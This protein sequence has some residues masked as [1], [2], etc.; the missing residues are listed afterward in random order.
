[1][2]SKGVRRE[3]KSYRLSNVGALP[4]RLLPLAGKR[5]TAEVAVLN[6]FGVALAADSAVTVD[7]WHQNK[8]ITKV[9]NSA[10]KVFTLSKFEPVGVLF[11]N[12]ATFG[13]IPW[14]TIVKVFRRQL[15]KTKLNTL[16]EYCTNF[17]G[18]LENNSLFTDA[19]VSDV[20]TSVFIRVFLDL[21]K[22]CKSKKDF[23]SKLDQE[24]AALSKLSNLSG[25]DDS[26]GRA[27]YRK[28]KANIELARKVV[29]KKTT[30]ISGQKRK[31]EEY[32]RLLFVK[33]RALPPYSGVVIAG[34]GDKEGLPRLREY[35][36]DI[37]VNGKVRHWMHNEYVIDENNTSKIVAF[38]DDDVWPAPGFEDAEL[39][40][41]MEPEVSHGETEVYPRVQA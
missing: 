10:N 19:Y 18:W 4:L 22:D 30:Y 11:Y 20:V 26:F 3:Q 25:F 37:V 1:V 33:G 35:I 27:A 38:A 5:M 32:A 29:L 24:I 31:I 9:Y 21:N 28:Y 2:G 17:F 23:I 41:F 7:H 16:E 13:G 34:F 12:A 40:V 39:G 8:V 15:H 6:K 36:V 14:E